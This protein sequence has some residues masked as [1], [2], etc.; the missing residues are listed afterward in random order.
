M[1][2]GPADQSRPLFNEMVERPSGSSRL[3]QQNR[4]KAEIDF[5]PKACCS[6]KADIAHR[7]L[8]NICVT[9]R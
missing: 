1:V 7:M 5:L 2:S 6:L 3:L 4:H 8:W 9:A